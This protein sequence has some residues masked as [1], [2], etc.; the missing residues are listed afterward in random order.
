MDEKARAKS[1]EA[2]LQAI[3]TPEQWPDA[4][5][6]IADVCQ[7]GFAIG[8]LVSPGDNKLTVSRGREG[9][10]AEYINGGWHRSNPRMARHEDDLKG[11]LKNIGGSR[12]EELFCGH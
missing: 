2:V 3:Y 8:Q 6:L 7:A 9:A 11:T 12:S 4:L 5:K 1:I 10:L